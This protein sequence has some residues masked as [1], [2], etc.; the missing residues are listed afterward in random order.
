MMNYFSIQIIHFNLVTII[1][2]IANDQP[3]AMANSMTKNLSN[4]SGVGYERGN[5]SLSGRKHRKTPRYILLQFSRYQYSN[6]EFVNM[7]YAHQ[8]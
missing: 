1:W 5:L 3:S 8:F 6:K 7:I 2:L 4:D